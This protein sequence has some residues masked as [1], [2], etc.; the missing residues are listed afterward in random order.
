MT[1]A[2]PTAD[3]SCEE[4]GVVAARHWDR[5]YTA[6]RAHILSWLRDAVLG[7]LRQT[8]SR[9]LAPLADRLRK[10]DLKLREM[11]LATCPARPGDQL[12]DSID[13]RLT[14]VLPSHT[15]SAHWNSPAE[16][17][18]FG[19]FQDQFRQEVQRW[20][21]VRLVSVFESIRRVLAAYV[22]W[23]LERFSRGVRLMVDDLIR[24]DIVARRPEEFAFLI[25]NNGATTER[26]RV[27][28]ICKL[29]GLLRQIPSSSTDAG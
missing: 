7:G 22:E 28:A 5:V 14:E 12:L 6:F 23:H 24:N 15:P 29:G 8:E 25:G 2:T 1:T 10:L 3:E 13:L 4:A 21:H 16:R 19:A 26:Q 9:L 18:P 17:E 20:F 11:S 27:Q